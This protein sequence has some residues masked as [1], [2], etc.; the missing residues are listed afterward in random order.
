[1]SVRKSIRNLSSNELA[2]LR[3]AYRH[4]MDISD[5]RGYKHL[6]G[7][8][9]AP[10]NKCLHGSSE[11]FDDPNFRL[12]LP[13]HRAYLY[14][15][16]K[17]LQD[18]HHDPN[19]TV[20]Y[21]DWTS[22]FSRNEG[23]PRAF[24]DETVNNLPNPLYSFHVNLSDEVNLDE[25]VSNTGCQKSRSFDTH[26]EPGSPLQLPTIQEIDYLLSL[27]DYGDFSD[28]L[29]DIHNRIHLWVGG[30]CGDMAYVPFSAY[31]P[32]FWSHHCTIDRLFWLWQLD[33]SHVLP[34]HLNEVV[35]E[36]FALTVG[37]VLNIYRLGYDYAG[38]QVLVEM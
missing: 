32:I 2:N 27:R 38:E 17:F 10:Y 7:I 34:M 37:Q 16:E 6:A 35:L 31:D 33:S 4:L 24:S 25:F 13:W 20:P 29:E 1:M 23:I 36:P 8:H 18:A 26:R 30:R 22:D 12:F 28:G 9:G 19:V 15:F 11:T 21:W 5:N 3:F 14:W